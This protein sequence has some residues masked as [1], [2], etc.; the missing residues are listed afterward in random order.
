LFCFLYFSFLSSEPV[1]AQEV[2][3]DAGSGT[4]AGDNCD[5]ALEITAGS[6]TGYL[7]SD[8]DEYDFIR[9]GL[10]RVKH[11]ASR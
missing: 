7:D 5:T 9:Y 6:Y 4:D 10:R 2:Q 3:D 11:W 8:Y 1:M